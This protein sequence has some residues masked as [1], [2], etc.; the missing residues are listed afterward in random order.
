MDSDVVKIKG[1]TW[2]SII[3]EIRINFWMFLCFIISFRLDIWHFCCTL[4][5]PRWCTDDV[6]DPVLGG[7]WHC[8]IC[9]RCFK[10]TDHHQCHQ[11]ADDTFVWIWWSR[12][13]SSGW[14]WTP[15][16]EAEGHLSWMLVCFGHFRWSIFDQN[17]GKKSTLGLFGW[18]NVLEK[19]IRQVPAYFHNLP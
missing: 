2:N 19:K 14:M 9:L 17:R 8:H 3:S 1:K 11:A 16:T 13:T 15:L 7:R 4:Q 6:A 10:W 12:E 5:V 18:I